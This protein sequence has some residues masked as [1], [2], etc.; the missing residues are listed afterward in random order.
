ML[1]IPLYLVLVSFICLVFSGKTYAS[2][3]NVAP[4]ASYREYNQETS[5]VS[6]GVA[7]TLD[8]QEDAEHGLIDQDSTESLT[9]DDVP[10]SEEMR[11]T[12]SNF[13]G[14]NLDDSFSW[15]KLARGVGQKA[16]QFVVDACSGAY[17]NVLRLGGLYC[18]SQHGQ[19]GG[20]YY[21]YYGAGDHCND[22][23]D[24]KTI[25]AAIYAVLKQRSGLLDNISCLAMLDGGIRRGTLVFGPYRSSWTS[26][27]VGC[28]TG[29]Y[30]VS[31]GTLLVSHGHVSS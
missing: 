4:S 8:N 6:I 10:E 25:G 1:T 18:A 11:V 2:A 31:S 7:L 24:L 19:M 9:I 14:S 17:M 16:K 21:R 23:A 3:P 15:G 13:E 26:N 12:D 20:L 5:V 30:D 29:E 22:I 28:Y 27:C